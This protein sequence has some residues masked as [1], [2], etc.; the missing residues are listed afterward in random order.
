MAFE[1]I[2]LGLTLTIP[3][4]GQLQWGPTVKNSTWKKISQH[5]HGG[6]GDGNPIE[7]AGLAAESVTS[8]KLAKNIAFKQ[9]ATLTP[10]GTTQTI[11]FNNGNM[12]ILNLGSATGDV[13]ATLSNPQAGA[14]YRIKIIQ[15]ATVRSIV[16]PASVLFP[17][18]INPTLHQNA[19]STNVIYLDYDGTNYLASLWENDLS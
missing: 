14:I 8:A 1:T 10:L 9:A 5:K 12:Q 13:T 19:S 2:S 3:T 4:S 6:G 17:G 15:G 18:G 16:W 7:A 11:D